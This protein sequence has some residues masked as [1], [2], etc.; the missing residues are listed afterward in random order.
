MNSLIDLYKYVKDKSFNQ[1][2]KEEK[3]E[4]YKLQ[5]DVTSRTLNPLNF[6]PTFEEFFNEK[7]I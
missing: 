7:N 5:F 1:F 4:M 2:S 6:N 3:E